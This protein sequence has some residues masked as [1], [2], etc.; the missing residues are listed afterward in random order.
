MPLKISSEQGAPGT[1]SR[2]VT[3]RLAFETT[4]SLLL[5]TG[6]EEG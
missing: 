6:K 5:P 3:D 2:P 1:D 4:D